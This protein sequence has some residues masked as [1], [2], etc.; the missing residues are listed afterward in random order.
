MRLYCLQNGVL[1]DAAYSDIN[2]AAYEHT[3]DIIIE[4]GAII[5]DYEHD[6]SDALNMIR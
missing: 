1:P 6:V 3:G 2:S 5:E 4:N